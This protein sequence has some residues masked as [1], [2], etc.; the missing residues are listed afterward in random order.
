MY[1]SLNV[2]RSGKE[3]RRRLGLVKGIPFKVTIIT[4][5]LTVFYFDDN[6]SSNFFSTFNNQNWGRVIKDNE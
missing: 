2:Q 4:V 3:K 5:S 1:T 6:T